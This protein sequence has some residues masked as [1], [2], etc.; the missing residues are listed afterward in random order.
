MSVWSYHSHAQ[1]RPQGRLVE[2]RHPPMTEI[3]F[4]MGKDVELLVFGVL[5]LMKSSTV[6]YVSVHELE[7]D[8]VHLVFLQILS[9]QVYPVL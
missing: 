2:A 5:V 9:W 8:K 7:R 4:K 1:N 6:V 3:G